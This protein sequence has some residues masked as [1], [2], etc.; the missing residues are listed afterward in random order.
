MIPS[1]TSNFNMNVPV[2]AK[3]TQTGTLTIYT[4]KNLMNNPYYDIAGNFS[5]YAGISRD[6]INIVRFSNAYALANQLLKE[7]SSPKADIVIGIDNALEN[8]FNA[9]NGT[10][11]FEP[12]TNQ[13]VLN[14]LNQNLIEN[15]GPNNNLIPYDYGVVGL[16][17][18]NTKLTSSMYPFLNNFTFDDLINS[19]LASKIVIENPE[20]SA[21]GL[22]FLLWTISTYGD[23]TSG[24][25]L[26]GFLSQNWR[27]FWQKLGKKFTIAPTYQDAYNMY[28]NPANGKLMVVS[29]TTTPAYDYCVQHTSTSSTLIT[30]FVNG[31]QLNSSAWFQIQGMGIV[32]NSPNQALANKFV[33]WFLSKDVQNE[34]PT[35]QWLYPANTK[36]TIPAC[37][38][39][40]GVPDPNKI[41]QL[42]NYANPS[43]LRYFLTTWMS[44]WS[45][46]VLS[47]PLPGFDFQTLAI[48]MPIFIVL[49]SMRK[50]RKF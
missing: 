26:H 36:A 41:V 2:Q 43:S 42:N 15:M 13:T 18:N 14:N 12:Y 45:Q 40:S 21:L 19:T 37:F 38:N 35:S 49:V 9:F 23:L 11:M 48:L 5:T 28:S 24:I 29:Y 30:S 27:P 6:K 25:F 31:T 32:R 39:Q 17:Y 3:T 8:A 46:T 16:Y 10:T 4:Y 33:G 44:E 1:F 34:I 50:K 47:K 22:G 7:K 20:T